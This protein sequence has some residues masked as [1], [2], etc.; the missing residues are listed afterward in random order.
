MKRLGDGTLNDAVHVMPGLGLEIARDTKSVG[1]GLAWTALAGDKLASVID[2]EIYRRTD[3]SEL[4]RPALER[5]LALN[6]RTAIGRIAAV[7]RDAR[8]ALLGLEAADL[9]ALAKSLSEGEL[10]TLASY[11]NGL[12]PG[13][14]EQVLR[15]VAGNPRLMQ[16]LA[17][18]RVRDAI[19]ASTDQPAA[20]D[21]MLR[22]TTG[23]SP[24][25]AAGDAVMAW[26][27]QI[28]PW[29]LLEKHPAG[30]ALIA[31]FALILLMWLGRLFRRGTPAKPQQTA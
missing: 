3:P 28:S 21:M 6:D 16:V 2:F 10:T 4:T 17:S 23:F 5:I 25:D 18:G 19:I 22:T 14:R 9:K 27:G 30:L 24:R 15:A 8:N 29:L 1:K 20:V 26:E 12:Q 11:L 31:A 13:P 7:P